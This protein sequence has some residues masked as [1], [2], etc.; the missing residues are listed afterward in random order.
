MVP[1]FEDCIDIVNTLWP[2][3]DCVFLFDHSCGHDRQRPD[4]LTV[5]GLKKGL[6]GAQPRMRDTRIGEDDS[7]IGLHA[8]ELTFRAGMVQSMQFAPTND[9][10]CWMN[11]AER[12]DARN[13]FSV[14][15]NNKECTESRRTEERFASKG[16]VGRR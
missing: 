1:Q 15:K 4:G 7:D 11:P 2:E 14:R 3:F 8:T 13:D 10:P 16:G 5:T 6:G 12:E 9:G